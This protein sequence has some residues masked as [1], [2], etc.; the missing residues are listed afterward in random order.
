LAPLVWLSSFAIDQE[1]LDHQHRELMA[2]INELTD[3]LFEGRPWSSV[4]AKSQELREDSI[5]YSKTEEEMLK[6]TAYPRLA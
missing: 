6:K 1:T 3:L 2:D 4:A 5:E